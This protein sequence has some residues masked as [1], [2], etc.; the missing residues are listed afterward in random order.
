MI[1]E[2]LSEAA[3]RGELLLVDG[4]IC[5]YHLRRDGQITIREILVLPERRH[6]GIGTAM[7]EHLRQVPGAV[8][9]RAWMPSDLPARRWYEEHGF[10]E[11]DRKRSGAGRSLTLWHLDL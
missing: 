10:V 7:L 2:A 1:F 3:D 4:G 8:C 9:I 5:H 6:Q 11:K